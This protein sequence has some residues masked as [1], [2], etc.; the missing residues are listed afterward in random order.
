MEDFRAFC[1]PYRRITDSHDKKWLQLEREIFKFKKIMALLEKDQSLTFSNAFQQIEAFEKES[2]R[3]VRVSYTDRIKLKNS[4]LD[5][6]K[7][8]KAI[9]SHRIKAESEGLKEDLN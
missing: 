4:Q 8:Y 6:Y 1:K 9:N 2:Q 5:L 3:G 7:P